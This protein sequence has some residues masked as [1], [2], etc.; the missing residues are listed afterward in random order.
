MRSI[1]KKLYR[2]IYEAGMGRKPNR[3]YTLNARSMCI[4]TVIRQCAESYDRFDRLID[5]E[6][7]IL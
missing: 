6:S 5:T 1:N 3:D 7:S 2:P 4:L